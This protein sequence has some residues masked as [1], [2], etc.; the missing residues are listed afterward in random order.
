MPDIL[1]RTMVFYPLKCR[2]VISF[3]NIHFEFVD[4][5]CVVGTPKIIQH[6]IILLIE[7]LKYFPRMNINNFI[8]FAL[9][10]FTV[11]ICSN[12]YECV[13]LPFVNSTIINDF[14]HRRQ[15]YDAFLHW[16]NNFII[17]LKIL[18]NQNSWSINLCKPFSFFLYQSEWL[19]CSPSPNAKTNLYFLIVPWSIRKFITIIARFIIVLT[20]DY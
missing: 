9:S 7:I 6:A 1:D 17:F 20:M 8:G 18:T 13:C 16:H 11:V 4:D 15:D 14:F 3:Y 19:Q 12:R 5:D 10:S 2:I